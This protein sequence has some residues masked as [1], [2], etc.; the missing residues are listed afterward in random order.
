M[1]EV[2]IPKKLESIIKA[3][4]ADSP[5]T[6]K[7]LIIEA[8]KVIYG[9]DDE[10]DQ[11]FAFRKNH[12]ITSEE[13]EGICALMQGI[14]PQDMLE[15]LFAAQIVVSHM[16]GLRKLAK[17]HK[18]DQYLGMK[19]LKFSNEAIIQLH[20]KRSGGL[21]NITVNYNYN[22]SENENIIPVIPTN[23]E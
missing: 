8:A 23:K 15:A 21:Q 4:Y 11:L 14:K 20:K 18:D 9:I 22:G 13:L 3:F 5:K 17:S 2:V 12:E 7:S 1:N 16:L 19:L 6:A 10:S